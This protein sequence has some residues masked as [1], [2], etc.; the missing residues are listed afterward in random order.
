MVINPHLYLVA[1]LRGR[2][3]RFLCRLRSSNST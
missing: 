1:R 3:H 2:P